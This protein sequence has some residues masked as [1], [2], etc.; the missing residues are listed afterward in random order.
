M[1]LFVIFKFPAIPSPV[2]PDVAWNGTQKTDVSIRR[3][4][5]PGTLQEGHRAG[6][7]D[8]VS[9]EQIL[10]QRRRLFPSVARGSRFCYTREYRQGGC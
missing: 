5:L 3:R 4:T 10:E 8:K 7:Q 6:A 2:R 9:E 1:S